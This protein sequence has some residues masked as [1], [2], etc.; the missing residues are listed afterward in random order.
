MRKS[1]HYHVLGIDSGNGTIYKHC[2]CQTQKQKNIL[3]LATSCMYTTR[4]FSHDHNFLK[5]SWQ[6]FENSKRLLR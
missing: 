3:W 1:S 6:V 5:A 2:H 4:K